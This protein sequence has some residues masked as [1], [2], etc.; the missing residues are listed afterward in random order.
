MASSPLSSV[1]ERLRHFWL[2]RTPPQVFVGSFLLLIAM[3]T[4]GLMTLPGLYT[5]AGL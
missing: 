1:R 2:S 4:L 3:G 5:G